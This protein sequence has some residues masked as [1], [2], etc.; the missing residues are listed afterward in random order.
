MVLS[1]G[2]RTDNLYKKYGFQ[3]FHKSMEPS[4][5]TAYEKLAGKKAKVIGSQKDKY[6][7]A[8]YHRVLV[9]D[10]Q[11]VFWYDIDERLDPT[12][13]EI[14]GVTF[15][16]QLPTVWKVT[17]RTDKMTDAKTCIVSPERRSP[18]PIFHFHSPEIVTVGIVGGNFPG[19]PIT[20]RVDKNRAISEA[21]ILTGARAKALVT[22]IRSGGER[23]LVRSHA[24]PHGSEAIHE[25]NL[26][27][28]L[29][30]LER[31]KKWAR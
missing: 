20:F 21:D 19:K 1:C 17:E 26:D 12:D 2:F 30:K 31:S 9:E 29:D 22:Q 8:T 14:G 24:W 28:I 11:I 23:M 16:K 15:I 6:G 27:G 7:I 13:G 3:F 25:F 18:Y 5:G 4:R 10:C